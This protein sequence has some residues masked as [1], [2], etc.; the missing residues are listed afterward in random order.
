MTA[1]EIIESKDV[2]Y[3]SSPVGYQFAQKID[4]HDISNLKSFLINI[5]QDEFVAESIRKASHEEVIQTYLDNGFT[6]DSEWYAAR[7]LDWQRI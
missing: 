2:L 1:K 7:L 5:F 6:F 4:Q 3:M